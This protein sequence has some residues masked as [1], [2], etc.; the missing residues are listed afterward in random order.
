MTGVQTCALPISVIRHRLTD[1]PGVQDVPPT[2]TIVQFIDTAGAGYDEEHE[3]DT[4]SRRN[5][6]EAKLVVHKVREHL[7]A[8]V[9]AEGIAIITPYSGQVRWLREL[10]TGTGVEIDSVDGFQGREKEVVILSFVRSNPE[11][12]LGFLKDIRRTNVAMT[13]A[14]RKLLMIGDSATLANEPFYQRLLTFCETLG[15]YSTVWEETI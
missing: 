14:K 4:S 7:D 3:E 13:R 2:A 1:L 8:G 9:P 12:E 6:M 10:L 11:G 15:A 5:P